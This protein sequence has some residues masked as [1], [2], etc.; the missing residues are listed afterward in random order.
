MGEWSGGVATLYDLPRLIYVTP[1]GENQMRRLNQEAAKQA[2]GECRKIRKTTKR[3]GVFR[4][5]L[6]LSDDNPY[7]HGS[8]DL[9]PDRRHAT[10]A[11]RK[12]SV[13]IS[14]TTR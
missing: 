3:A 14:A 11:T 13:Q 12:K 6:F 9:E 10:F 5:F 2:V 4:L 7:D 8:C 1:L